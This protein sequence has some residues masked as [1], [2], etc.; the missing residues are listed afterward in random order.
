M[1]E[2][3]ASKNRVQ[4]RCEAKECQFNKEG[5]CRKEYIVIDDWATCEDCE[6]EASD[7]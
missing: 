7:E 4:V 1:G 3:E 5:W 6:E 2:Q